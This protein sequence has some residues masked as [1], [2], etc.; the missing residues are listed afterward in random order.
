MT[1]IIIIGGGITGLSAAWELQQRAGEQVNL[2]V[3]EADSRWGGKVLTQTMPSPEPEGGGQFVIDAGPESFVTRKPAA[4]Q[5]TRELGLVEQAFNPGNEAAGTYV[6]DHGRV[7]PLPLGPRA[8]LTTDLL[9]WRGKLRLLAEPFI[10]PR[11]DGGDESLAE[12]VTRRLGPE[13]LEKVVGPVLGGIYNSDPT[14]QS[15]LITA[16]IMRELE[17]Q[18]SL[19]WGTV[20]HSRRRRREL[21]QDPHPPPGRFLGFP[22]GAQVLVEALT[23]QLRGDL[24]LNTAVDTLSLLPDGSGALVSLGNGIELE[25]QAVIIATPANVA[26]RLL[27]E[28]DT[29]VAG[30]LAQIRHVDIGTV[31]LAYPTEAVAHIAP[32]RGLMIPRREGRRIDAVTWTSAK[33]A[34]RAPAGYELLRVF[35]G[36]GDSTAVGLPDDEL[37]EMVRGELADLLNITAVPLDYRI[38]RWPRSY[39]QADVGHLDLVAA[40]E[41]A[42][43]HPFYVTGSSYR[44]LAVPDCIAQARETA[45]RVWEVVGVES[46][47]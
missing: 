21:A 18:G 15:V 17:A 16:P 26:A 30:Q 20:K 9:S 25:A 19:V 34:G 22:T 27:Q 3:L 42:L 5:L 45:R 4:W 41:Q 31:S 40:I 8:M 46:G 6:L 11:L 39:P 43:P 47:K 33:I 29:A 24:R 23:Q 36:G 2:T 38:A 37:V 10:P 1:H 7:R 28:V 35:F 44:G 14:T 12:F 32:L 13:M